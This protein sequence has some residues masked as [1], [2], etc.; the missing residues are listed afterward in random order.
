MPNRLEFLNEV[1]TVKKLITKLQ[2]DYIM[3]VGEGRLVQWIED[4]VYPPGT[5]KN[6]DF[7]LISHP[8]F[9]HFGVFLA[10]KN[11]DLKALLQIKDFE[12]LLA[13]EIAD[14]FDNNLITQAIF[15][16]PEQTKDKAISQLIN[17]IMIPTPDHIYDLLEELR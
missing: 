15:I 3:I 14:S 13:L 4:T 2:S 1:E 17:N 11:A 7:E 9:P 16:K 10:K 12:N 5:S 8:T 6:A